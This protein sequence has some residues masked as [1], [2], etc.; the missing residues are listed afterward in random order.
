MSMLELRPYQ[1][2]AVDSLT[3]YFEQNFGNPLVVIPTAGGKSLVV[4]TFVSEA[5]Q[6][7]PDT[8][9][10]VLT[11]VRE[12]I[13][14][15]HAELMG[16]WPAAP[17]GIYSAGLKKRDIGAQI[18]F[19]GI[20]SIHAKAYDLQHVD[21]VLVDEA[22]L[23]P[24][25]SNTMYGR[26]LAALHDIN[27]ALKVIGFTA[28]PFRLDSGLLCEGDDAVFS[29]VAFDASIVDLIEQGYL[30]R[31]VS[32][33]GRA[34]IDT[35]RVGTRG[36]EFIANQLEAAALDPATVAAVVDEIVEH[37]QDRRG[38]LVFACGKKHG[39]M[40]AEQLRA[41]GIEVAEIYGDTPADDRDRTI[42]DFKDQKTR[43][44]VS[45]GV[46]TT[47]FNARHVDMIAVVRP[48]K[49]TGLWIQIVGRGTRLF[50]GKQ[51]CLV[52]DFG[53]CIARHGPIDRPV[54]RKQVGTG[55]G[56]APTKICRYCQAENALAATVCTACG[57]EFPLPERRVDTSA[58]SL[59][60][61]SG[62]AAP[63]PPEWV[64][65]DAVRYRKHAKPGKP[66]SLCVIYDSGLAQHR[67]WICLEHTGFARQKAEHWW[68]Q[69]A[70]GTA[71]PLTVDDALALTSS[72]RQPTDI[73]IQPDGKYV[74]VM[75]AS[76]A[77]REVAA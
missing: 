41:A 70:P 18:L 43:C 65:V 25:S 34:Q 62:K 64:E 63:P 2:E 45:I 10:L 33:S 22:H 59:D 61:L 24:R 21:L 46:L 5:L 13:A 19:A 7:F 15:N 73:K 68:R 27:P 58:S 54:V 47:G 28:T 17:A 53:G 14:Q 77:Q 56:D 20:Q 67:E 51:D 49:S 29:D 48:T 44:L 8:R 39:A 74:R 32:L 57:Q 50:P 76:F 3:E 6:Q 72:M 38:W 12:L 71:V 16:H 4:A 36:G 1:R 31:P 75:A 40:M 37:G 69:R 30:C 42:A 11:H 66:P 23:I 9:I 35:S 55:G 26:F 60:I 52:L